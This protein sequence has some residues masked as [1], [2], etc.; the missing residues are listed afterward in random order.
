MAEQHDGGVEPGA[1]STGPDR[2]Q[3]MQQAGAVGAGIALAGALAADA[4]APLEM[5]NTGP[6]QIPRK[7]F[8]KT[9]ESVSIIGLGGYSLGSAPSLGGS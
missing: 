6:D 2:R 3:F 9:G 5:T 1:A 4:P 8:G 7:P